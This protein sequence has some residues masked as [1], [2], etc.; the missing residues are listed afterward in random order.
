MS[1]DIIVKKGLDLKLVGKPSNEIE[2]AKFSQDF[3]VYPADF[4]GVFPKLVVKE[5]EL[6]KAGDILF[7]D[8]NS[9]KVKFVS[10]V[11]GK[12]KEIVRGERRRV[13]E[14][15]IHADK[16]ITYKKIKKLKSENSSDIIDYLLENGL[17]TYIK[18]RPY[19][20]IADPESSPKEIFI[21]GFD[22][23]P[24]SADYDFITKDQKENIIEAI[25]HLSKLTKGSVNISLRKESN[26]FLRELNDVIIHNVSGPHPAGNLSTIINKVSPI[27]KGDTVWT[28]NLPDL[29]IIGNT[30]LNGKFSPERIVALVGSSIS[31]PKYYKTLAGSNISTFLNLNEKNSRIISGN[32]FTGT[33]I[34]LNGHLRHYSNEITA[35]PEGNDYD[36][37]G[38]A[39]PMFEKFSVSRALTFSWLFPDKKYDLNTNT[40]G[41]HRA[42]VVTGSFEEVFP[43]DIYPMQILKACMYKDL[44]EMEALGMYEVSP[45]DFALTEF[46]CVS[47]Q[48][49]QSIIREGLDLMKKE[50]G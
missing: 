28:L 29:A 27:N 10:P 30:I 39:K 22:S 32:V 7:F 49:H 41:E 6:V 17:W 46:I 42:F 48:P 21:S 33:M 18:Q 15:K 19:D 20:V 9:E 26:S 5:N 38:W 45:E 3:A 8:K 16:E 47:K 43:L 14:I 12:I 2:Q 11:S 44:D 23:S 13:L 34:N 4:H 24:L 25:K 31:K 40:N 50:I 35:I 37:F 36:L 1:M